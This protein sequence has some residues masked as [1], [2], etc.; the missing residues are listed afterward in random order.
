MM[1]PEQNAELY[2]SSR[3]RPQQFWGQQAEKFITWSHPFESIVQ[4]NLAA[5]NVRWFEGG[6]LNACYNCVDR[7]LPTRANDIA[8]IW[9]S[10][11]PHLSTKLTFQQL[12]ENVCRLANV[13]KDCGIAKGDRVCIYLPMIVE[14][15]IAMLA[16]ARI[17]AVHA[18]VFG[19]FS[20]E[21][22]QTRINDAAC[23]L[24]VTADEGIRGNK[25]I[26]LKQ[27]TD[28]ALK[29]CPSVKKVIV[30][31]RTANTTNWQ[32]NR[33]IDYAKAMARAAMEC[34]CEP[35]EA[36]EPLFILYTSGSTGKPKGI[37]HGTGGYL[38]YAAMT[39]RYIFD[40]QPGDI[41]WCSADVG[42]ITG[43]AY[44]VYGPLLNGATT[45]LFEGTPH[46]PTHARYWEIIDKHQVNIFYTSPTAI[47]ALRQEG[48]QFVKRTS[49]QS[50]KILGSVGEPINAAVWQWYFDVVGE[51]RC[52]IVDTWW[53]TETG[54][55]MIAPLPG[56]VSE[57]GSAGKPFFG[58]TASVVD[59]EG[60][61]VSVNTR[62]KLVI[63]QCWPG[64]MLTIFDDPVRFKETYFTPGKQ[65][66][67]TGD[68]AY[69]DESGNFWVTGRHDDVIKVS[70]HRIGTGELESAIVQHPDISEAAVVS[71]AHA[72]K[73]N[74]IY[75]FVTPKSNVTV[76]EALKKALLLEVRK[77]I[78]AIA[79]PDHIQWTTALPKTRSGKIMR[80]ILRQIANQQFDNFG[81]TS[82]LADPSVIQTLMK[83]R[84]LIENS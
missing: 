45:V 70:G 12:H 24:V 78:G 38:V 16:C 73:G 15:I 51:K 1:T 61:P 40:Y 75:A 83:D 68:N 66:Y 9:E 2:Q 74:A 26:P 80:R 33:D 3:A 13:F 17:G 4:G 14:V 8:I 49:R 62:G 10:D 44:L 46:Y 53:Q 59:E 27:N 19:G 60:Q 28:Q 54:G 63:T 76:S 30:V 69:Q 57:P 20:A 35:M 65:C 64:M 6:K 31:S 18:V 11:D 41:Y 25:I 43:H 22:L 21:S 29:A 79:V 71:V 34:A 23:K 32:E 67:I 82:T 42:W 52:N 58:I 56:S 36:N 72:I 84:I 39:H 50:L 47:R 55:I 77:A 7:H 48:D 37:V 81:D 5:Q